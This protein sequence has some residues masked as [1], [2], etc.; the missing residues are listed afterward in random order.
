VHI[1]SAK[2]GM[3]VRRWIVVEDNMGGGQ[4]TPMNSSAEPD[5]VDD[6]MLDI[7]GDD[8]RSANALSLLL[9]LIGMILIPL[10][11]ILVFLSLTRGETA[12]QATVAPRA[13][14][15]FAPGIAALAGRWLIVGGD[16]SWVSYKPTAGT[17]TASTP[18][19]L[20]F[21]TFSVDGGIVIEGT[22]PTAGKVKSVALNADLT[23]LKSGDADVDERLKTSGLETSAFPYAEFLVPDTDP[24]EI[25]RV[26]AFGDRLEL[27][28]T[29]QLTLRGVTREVEMTLTAQLT[30]SDPVLIELVG[31]MPVDVAQFG[32]AGG[33]R[34]EVSFHLR[35]ARVPDEVSGDPRASTTST[36]SGSIAPG[37][38]PPGS[39]PP[40]TARR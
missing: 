20:E 38:V 25:P 26:P 2:W 30:Q 36:P 39:N 5:D 27:K 1:D 37:S 34:G 4:D 13:V 24:I 6:D 35:L 15:E 7:P 16:H 31:T 23:A 21:K 18:P 19:S 3:L 11:L 10:G 12:R 9:M 22:T 8:E 33:G 28:A 40:G 32:I 14:P 29:G 17:S